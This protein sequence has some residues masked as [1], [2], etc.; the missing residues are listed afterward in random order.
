MLK[1]TGPQI[2]LHIVCWLGVEKV[3]PDEMYVHVVYIPDVGNTSVT[4]IWQNH[5]MTY[6]TEQ[7]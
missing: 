6:V 1:A 2:R 5:L 3:I 4:S 7:K